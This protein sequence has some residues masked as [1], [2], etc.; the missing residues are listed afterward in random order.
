MFALIKYGVG[1]TLSIKHTLLDWSRKL[2]RVLVASVYFVYHHVFAWACMCV[3]FGWGR[4][5]HAGALLSFGR[6]VMARTGGRPSFARFCWFCSLAAARVS[7]AHFCSFCA[8]FLPLRVGCRSNKFSGTF[9]SWR[10]AF[11]PCLF[12]HAALVI[13]LLRTIVL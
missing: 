8:H 5:T 10:S 12:N 2:V 6:D 1:C 4:R 13:H 11:S 3:G 9:L 7:L